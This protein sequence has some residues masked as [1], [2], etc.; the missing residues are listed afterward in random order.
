M[1]W[2]IDSTHS[3][4][5]FAVK[6]LMISTVKGRFNSF[7]GE[8]E[9]NTDGTLKAVQVT[10]DPASIDTREEKRDAHLKSPDFFDIAAHPA[11]TFQSANITQ[12]GSDISITGNLTIR[13]TTRPVT[14][15]GE[16]NAP[17]SDPWGGTRAGLAVSTKINRKDFGLTWNVA[18]EA[19]GFVVGEDVRINIEVEAIAVRDEV[20][21]A[22]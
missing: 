5:E 11:I 20:L 17:V 2:T 19:G 16:Y 4:A 21:A 10:I 1:K 14:L 12:H 13:G 9:T 22:A 15:T 8:G 3:A 18:L 6:H 7:T